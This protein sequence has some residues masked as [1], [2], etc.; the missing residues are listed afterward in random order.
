VNDEMAADD[1]LPRLQVRQIWR[2]LTGKVLAV[3]E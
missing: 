2:I 1:S 3:R